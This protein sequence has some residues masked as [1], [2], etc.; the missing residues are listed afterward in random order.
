MDTIDWKELR[1][2]LPEDIPFIPR[3]ERV[4]R[5]EAKAIGAIR[6]ERRNDGRSIA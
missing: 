6:G 1:V 4:L 5:F 3:A 2:F